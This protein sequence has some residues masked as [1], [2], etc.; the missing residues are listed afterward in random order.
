MT[1]FERPSALQW[2]QPVRRGYKMAYC[3][4]GLVHR[5][6][7]RVVEGRVQFR[8]AR[9][10]RSTAMKRRWRTARAGGAA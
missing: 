2:V 8:V 5:M 3:D 9:D 6:D 4:C 10:N 7:F 1:T